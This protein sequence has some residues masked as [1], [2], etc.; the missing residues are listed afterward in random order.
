MHSGTPLARILAEKALEAARRI[1][2]FTVETPLVPSP[3]LSR[4]VG[5]RVY[6]KLENVQVTGSF[7]ARGVFNKL[8]HLQEKGARIKTV[9]TGS[10]GNHGV[11]VAY[12]SSLL[13]LECHVVV[14]ET[15][16]KPKLAGIREYG[17]KVTLYG[18]DC[19]EAEAYAR[20]LAVKHGWTFIS[21][22][23]DLE[24]IAGHATIAVEV[25]ARL[26]SVDAILVPVGAGG[27]ASGLAAYT[28]TLNPQATIVG[29]QAENSPVMYE[30]IKA[31]RI[32]E[33]EVKPTIADGVAGGI[34]PDSITFELCRSLVDHWVLVP[35]QEIAE[36]ILYAL[37]REHIL[38]EGAAALP[39]AALQRLRGRLNA[40]TIVLVLTGSRID[41]DLL[42]KLL[43][44]KL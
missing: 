37:E 44:Q 30:S 33:I 28:K 9:V 21:P 14:P 34:E 43:N 13:G 8:L 38:L 16:A 6:L 31:G 40:K 36:A 39:I 24:V 10:T 17:C 25:H 3:R 15:V 22:Y 2:G 5:A 32:V 12:A 41:S 23:N 18:R 7:K 29:C 27:L 11:A 42:K 1:K 26:G 20:N 35:E 19:L 4:L